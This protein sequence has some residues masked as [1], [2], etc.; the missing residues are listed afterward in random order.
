MKDNEEIEI[1]EEVEESKQNIL[2]EESK[3]LKKENLE[4]EKEEDNINKSKLP[5]IIFIVMMIIVGMM[6]GYTVIKDIMIP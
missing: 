3:E 4:E 2:E 1:L 6:I 5:L